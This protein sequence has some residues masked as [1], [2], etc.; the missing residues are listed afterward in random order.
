MSILDV[1]DVFIGSTD[2]GHT[3]VI[4]NRHIR[5]AHRLLTTAGLLPREHLDRTL[6]LLPPDTT[7]DVRERA[8]IAMYRL[9]AHTHDLVDL[10]W[11][12]RRSPGQPAGAPDLHFRLLRAP[13]RDPLPT[14]ARLHPLPDA[15]RQPQDA[16][17][18]V[19]LEADLLDRRARAEAEGWVGETEG[20]DLTLTFLRSKRDETQRRTQRPS[21]DLGIP[22]PRRHRS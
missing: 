17:R 6:Y 10:A 20:I 22:T 12:T 11:A 3:F 19:E 5:D 14:R 2:D 16:A 1:P 13:L 7:R 18:L 8:G 21:V 15:P 4:L 9:L